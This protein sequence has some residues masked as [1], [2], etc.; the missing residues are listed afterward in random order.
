MKSLLAPLLLILIVLPCTLTNS[1]PP[2]LA[3][4][5]CKHA[6]CGSP[7]H[8]KTYWLW[9]FNC[10]KNMHPLTL[11][12]ALLRQAWGSPSTAT[13][14]EL[15]LRVETIEDPHTPPSFQPW[16]LDQV[17]LAC[18]NQAPAEWPNTSMKFSPRLACP[19]ARNSLHKWQVVNTVTNLSY[20]C[21]H[22]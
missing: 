3:L 10:Q 14:M 7:F 4:G 5:I 19:G 1:M 20:Q 2:R 13:L 21:I 6:A 11:S 15:R 16:L 9:R 22:N 17:F 8:S 18:Q 12:L